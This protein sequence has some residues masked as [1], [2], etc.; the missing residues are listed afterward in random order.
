MK[1]WT[2]APTGFRYTVN[3]WADSNRQVRQ[4]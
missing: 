3:E 2:A 1:P 4:D